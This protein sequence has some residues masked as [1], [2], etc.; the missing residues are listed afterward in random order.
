MAMAEN[1]GDALLSLRTDDAR[2]NQGIDRAEG[3]AR[4]LETTLDK[5]TQSTDRL[6]REMVDTAKKSDQL[7]GALDRQRMRGRENVKSLGAQRVG[8]QQLTMQGNDMITMYNLGARPSQIFASQIGQVTQAVTL[9][10]GGAG[11][12]ASFLMGGWGLALQ[13]ALVALAPFI[14]RLFEAEEAFE[15]AELAGSRFGDAQSILGTVIDL[16]TG[17][18]KNQ[19]AAVRALAQAQIIQG[20]IEEGAAL[21]D[22]TG[23]LASYN[24]TRDPVVF[25]GQE[26]APGLNE[27]VDR[28]GSAVVAFRNG[29]IGAK[30]AIARLEGQLTTGDADDPAMQ[31]IQAISDAG[32]A[33]ANLS[34]FES[35]D[36]A[37]NGNQ[38]ALQPF[39]RPGRSGSKKTAKAKKG[40]DQAAIDAQF[41]DQLTGITQRILRARQQ[42]AETAEERAEL[43]AR[44]VEWTRLS[45]LADI[46]A[47]KKLSDAQKAELSAATTRLAD[48]ELAVIEQAKERQLL[49]ERAEV[50]RD[51]RALADER[52]R[53]QTTAL[54]DQLALADTEA[55]RKRIA[56]QLF[57]A[58]Q[59]MLRSRLMAV[60]FSETATNAERE[61]AEIALRA[62]RD[63]APAAQAAASRANETTLDRFLRDLDKTPEQINE[64]LD[65]ISVDGLQTLEDSI[66]NVTRGVGSLGDLF[67]K[68][69]DQIIADL[70]RIA[71]Q[72]AITKPLAN[73]LFG[74]GGSGGSAGGLGGLFAGLFAD[75]GTIPRGQFGI[76][77][78]EGPEAVFATARGVQVLP[79]SALR[80]VPAEAAGAGDANV[81][82]NMPVDATGADPAAIGRLNS[83]LD[84]LER[85]L[86]V[87]IVSVVRDAQ[88]R[89]I[90]GG[91]GR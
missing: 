67:S 53:G 32:I 12:F 68:V 55:Q 79:N 72:Q 58:E 90:L 9:A 82:I 86:D 45:S 30:A 43:Q 2:F 39:L 22:A 59:A 29:E 40:P 41:D 8:M 85:N 35:A 87:T 19:T 63:N 5:T 17:K 62:L 65:L 18:I 89:R 80:S 69:A 15:A 77:G 25:E 46:A 36:Q 64:A 3:R 52:Y 48:A 7:S 54:R 49:Q 50:E 76:V 70:A 31:A 91:G 47:D 57:E 38:E 71:I 83:R 66:V 84:G 6:G 4:K 78:E 37:L 34:A 60:I 20:K 61:R 28:I 75:G 44:Q 14:G 73:A 26:I 11:R 16:T 21:R 81:T 24:A 13:I 51:I 74:A 1:L 23:R 27:R 56:L 88:E 10:T 42:T 33:G